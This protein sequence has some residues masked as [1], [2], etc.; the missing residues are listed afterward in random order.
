M[1]AADIDKDGYTDLIGR[2]DTDADDNNNTGSVFWLKNPYGNK[3]YD[4]KPWVKTDIGL[5]TYT[6]DIIY[7]C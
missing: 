4:G 3:N 1:T 6:K 5:S 7:V 2:Y